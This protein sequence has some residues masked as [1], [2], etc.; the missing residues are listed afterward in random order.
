MKTEVLREFILLAERGSLSQVSRELFIAR[1]TLASHMGELE[2]EVGVPLFE[3]GNPGR[4]TE[5]GCLLLDFARPIVRDC[6]TAVEL[7]RQTAASAVL[8]AVRVAYSGATPAMLARLRGLSPVPLSM[9]H[10]DSRRP[11]FYLFGAEEDLCDAQF[12]WDFSSVDTMVEEAR[13][14][15]VG[16]VSTGIYPYYLCVSK[17]SGLGIQGDVSLADLQGARFVCP[18]LVYYRMLQHVIEVTFGEGLDYAL[19]SGPPCNDYEAL[20]SLDLDDRVFLVSAAQ[21]RSM[22]GARD[23]VC[24]IDRVDGKPFGYPQILMFSQEARAQ[25]PRLAQ[26][27]DAVQADAAANGGWIQTDWES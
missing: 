6:D 5:A 24:F 14:L 25:N 23:D 2:R 27:I 16:W 8:G 20:I 13:R 22:L 10:V 19:E 17:S 1:T 9:V 12:Q 15:G 11:F 7:C 21:A 18:A 4:L 3:A 26:F